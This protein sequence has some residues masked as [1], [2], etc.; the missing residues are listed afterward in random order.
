MPLT[1]PTIAS[2]PIA[3]FPPFATILRQ[4]TPASLD[5]NDRPAAKVMSLL[6]DT[7]LQLDSRG[8]R[9]NGGTLAKR[10]FPLALIGLGRRR[11]R[12]STHE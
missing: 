1:C 10:S 2:A 9:Y 12:E 11:G 8:K 5:G 4:L 6:I 7:S 3:G